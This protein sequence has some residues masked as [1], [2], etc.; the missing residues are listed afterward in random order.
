MRW[1]ILLGVLMAIWLV[2]FVLLQLR[3]MAQV[4]LMRGETRLQRARGITARINCDQPLDGGLRTGVVNQRQVLLVLTDRRLVLG[5]WRGVVLDARPGDALE[6]RAPG[7]RRLVLEGLRKAR[8][9]QDRDCQL[10][11]ELLLDRP[12]PWIAGLELLLA[13]QAVRGPRAPS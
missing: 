5:T 6:L 10:R 2:G 11:L 1:T 3:R 8:H 12:D 13:T 7:P 9:E 4:P